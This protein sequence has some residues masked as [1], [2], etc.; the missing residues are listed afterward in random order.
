MKVLVLVAILTSVAVLATA[1]VIALYAHKKA[2]AGVIKL[3]GE[4]GYVDTELTPIGTVIVSG[5]LWRARSKDG[6]RL[7]TR[8]RVRVVGFADQ[9]A[10]VEPSE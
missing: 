1:I 8:A 10:V 9:L 7:P 3:I 5:E 6:T 2:G 4:V